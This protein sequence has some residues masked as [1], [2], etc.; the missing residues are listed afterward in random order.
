VTRARREGRAAASPAHPRRAL[1]V[2]A[3]LAASWP[4]GLRA[5]RMVRIGVLGLARPALPPSTPMRT[6]RCAPGCASAAGSRAAT[7]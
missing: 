2:W 4:A 1:L 3:G 5:Q 7:W 6:M